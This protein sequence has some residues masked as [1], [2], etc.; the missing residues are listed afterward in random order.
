M[1]L[2][3]AHV[4]V[5]GG[6]DGI[7]RATALA[8]ARA[9]ARLSVCGRTA[10]KLDRIRAEL[11]ASTVTIACDLAETAQHASLL[12][13]ARTAHGPIDVLVNNAGVQTPMDFTEAASGRPIA[14]E[15]AV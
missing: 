7:G 3:G 12:D 8:L 11:P 2:D 13:A 6:S 5:T 4:L 1:K 14:G 10:H 9:G 15:V